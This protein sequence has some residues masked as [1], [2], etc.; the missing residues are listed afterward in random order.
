MSDD[1]SFWEKSK[2]A[3]GGAISDA[4]DSLD[5][6]HHQGVGLGTNIEGMAP[7]ADAAADDAEDTGEEAKQ[8]DDSGTSG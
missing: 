2:D 5:S 7:G 3:I 6:A 1:K 4:G 8:A